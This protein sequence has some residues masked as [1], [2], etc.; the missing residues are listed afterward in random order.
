MQNFM[1]TRQ[2]PSL[3]DLKKN[4]ERG[5]EGKRIRSLLASLGIHIS[6]KLVLIWHNLP[7]ACTGSYIQ[8]VHNE[9][10]F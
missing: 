4:P 10:M 6:K 9:V 5:G 2:L 1:R 8:T 7:L 3:S